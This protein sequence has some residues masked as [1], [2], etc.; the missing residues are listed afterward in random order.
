VGA[1]ACL[2]FSAILDPE[3]FL[4]TLKNPEMRPKRFRL[5]RRNKTFLPVSLEGYDCE[6]FRAF[7]YFENGRPPQLFAGAGVTWLRPKRWEV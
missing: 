3:R 2:G 4:F 6:P 1:L 5:L 7:E